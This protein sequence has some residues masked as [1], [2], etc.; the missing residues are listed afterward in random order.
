MKNPTLL[1]AALALLA[2]TSSAQIATSAACTLEQTVD[3]NTAVALAV[4]DYNFSVQALTETAREEGISAAEQTSRLQQLQKKYDARAESISGCLSPAC[5]RELELGKAGAHYDQCKGPLA[6]ALL[7]MRPRMH[8]AT[9][10]Y[11]QTGG[12]AVFE[13]TVRE[14]LKVVVQSEPP[15][16]WYEQPPEGENSCD[17]L[18]SQL[19]A[20]AYVLSMPFMGHE[21]DLMLF[22]NS[23]PADFTEGGSAIRCMQSLGNALV[24]RGLEMSRQFK[25]RSATEIFG[26]KMP[27][28]LEH[29]PGQVDNSMQSY[30][31]GGISVGQELLCVFRRCE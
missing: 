26:G 10:Q 3:Y 13:A 18:S 16:C 4:A 9:Q 1:I 7:Q 21:N 25:G 27:T 15:I 20:H 8:S 5:R 23:N 31:Y 11:M 19:V 22:M 24:N 6:A 30:G 28:G 2:G 29:L 17:P 14:I 12:R